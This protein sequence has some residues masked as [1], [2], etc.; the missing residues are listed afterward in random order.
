VWLVPAFLLY[1]FALWV[2]TNMVV[3]QPATA[4]VPHAR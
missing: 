2:L 3:Q 4:E 1:L